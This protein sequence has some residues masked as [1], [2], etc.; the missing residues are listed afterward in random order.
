M[1]AECP[2]LVLNALD[3]RLAFRL[4]QRSHL[5]VFSTVICGHVLTSQAAHLQIEC[6]RFVS[7]DGESTLHG[8]C[9]VWVFTI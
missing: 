7:V 8:V 4:T 6:V 2:L 9:V 1:Y 5:C 3:W